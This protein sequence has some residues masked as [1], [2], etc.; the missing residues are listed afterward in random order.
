MRGIEFATPQALWLLAVA[1]P[2]AWWAW[3][4][5]SRRAVLRFSSGAA[6]VR[7]PRGWRARLLWLLPV[8]RLLAIAAAIVALARPQERG[9]VRRDLSIEGID[10]MIAIDV[11]TSMEAD[12]FKPNNR[13]FVA[14]NVLS[15]FID[16]RP[17]D[18]LGLVVFA[19]QAFTQAPLT[20]DHLALTDSVEQL[21]TRAL[22]DG[23]AIGDAVAL[24]VNRLRDSEA[25]S[26]VVVLITD[27]DNNAGRMSPLDAAQAAQAL[28]IKVFTILVGKGGLVRFPVGVDPFGRQMFRDVD[29]EVNPDLLKEI[30]QRTNAGF[31]RATDG[32]GLKAGLRSV[33]DTLERSKLSEGGAVANYVEKFHAVLFLAAILVALELFLRSTVFRVTP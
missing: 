1:V 3:Y 27:G 28:G 13:L 20:F 17:N 18:R 22:P 11:S 26:R 16:A 31:Y 8:L 19:G 30:A 2:L 23:T 10:I 25:K 29:L 12:D 5:K 24:A 14:K 15:E 9:A 7:G 4:E 6:F 32:A 33:L 21:K